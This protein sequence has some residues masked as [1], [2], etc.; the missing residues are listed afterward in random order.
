MGN[1]PILN[2]NNNLMIKKR[3]FEAEC[4]GTLLM[5]DI[6]YTCYIFDVINY[7]FQ[8]KSVF[9]FIFLGLTKS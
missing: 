9:F 4:R 1:K 3:Y 2:Q 6:K 8:I 5:I 7:I